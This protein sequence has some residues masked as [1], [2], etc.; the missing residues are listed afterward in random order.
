MQEEAGPSEG[1]DE[2]R[3]H[4][5]GHA[6]KRVCGRLPYPAVGAIAARRKGARNSVHRAVALIGDRHAVRPPVK[7]SY[8]GRKPDLDRGLVLH[9]LEENPLGLR[10]G[11]HQQLGARRL[12]FQFLDREPEQDPPRSASRS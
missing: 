2:G 12:P 3:L 11:T 1:G 6:L 8:L 7:V 4:V 5:V 9:G 10:L